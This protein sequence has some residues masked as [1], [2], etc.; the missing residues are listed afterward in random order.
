MLR[1]T[2]DKRMSA[3]HYSPRTVQSNGHFL[4]VIIIGFIR[5]QSEKSIKDDKTRSASATEPSN[6]AE[7]RCWIQSESA[8]GHL[9]HCGVLSCAVL[10]SLLM[11]DC[12]MN[13]QATHRYLI[14]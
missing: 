1:G 3:G 11:D 8:E 7:T 14:S 5:I 9:I 12:T 6:S 4:L 10:A 2:F 13:I